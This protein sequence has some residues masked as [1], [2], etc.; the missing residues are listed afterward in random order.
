MIDGNDI[1]EALFSI[2]EGNVPD[3]MN[4]DTCQR[5]ADWIN[6]ATAQGGGGDE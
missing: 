1:W 4:E 3:K 6:A 2:M 5:L